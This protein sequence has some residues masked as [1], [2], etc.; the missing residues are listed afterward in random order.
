MV[1]SLAQ[2]FKTSH[3]FRAEIL[4]SNPCNCYDAKVIVV[5]KTLD[6]KLFEL[7]VS[8]KSVIVSG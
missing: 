1:I 2:N 4:A 3:T 8:N 5:K 7:P 6:L